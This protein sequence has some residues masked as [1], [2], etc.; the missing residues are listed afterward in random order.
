MYISSNYET[1]QVMKEEQ[2]TL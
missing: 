1:F 2:L